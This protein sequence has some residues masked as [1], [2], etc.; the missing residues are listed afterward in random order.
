MSE[1]THLLS[2]RSLRDE[3]TLLLSPRE[4]GEIE[5]Q[6]RTPGGLNTVLEPL[7]I[8]SGALLIAARSAHA[9][10]SGGGQ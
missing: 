1:E 4:N 7:V 6:I 5:V 2:I 3:A 8:P 10:A 9:I